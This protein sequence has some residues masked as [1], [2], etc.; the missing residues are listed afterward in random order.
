MNLFI[1]IGYSFWPFLKKL[2]VSA[3]ESYQGFS[4]IRKRSI[5]SFA[6]LF[7]A[8][9]F[10][11][12]LSQR[13]MIMPNSFFEQKK[14]VAKE[15]SPEFNFFHVKG[16]FNR[17]ELW[18]LSE[19]SV[20][21]VEHLIL[22]ST[23]KPLR[24]RLKK[25]LKEGLALSSKYQIDPFWALAIMWTESH[26]N[27]EAKSYA[28]ASGLMQLMPKTAAFLAG[29][30]NWEKRVPKGF[31][32]RSDHEANMELGIFY[33]NKLLRRFK[34]NATLATVAYNMGPGWVSKQIEKKGPV[35]VKNNYL[36]KVRRAYRVL[37][38]SYRMYLS[39]TRPSFANTYFSQ[40]NHSKELT[41][42]NYWND[43]KF[44]KEEP[45]NKLNGPKSEFL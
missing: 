17:L 21:Q 31:D 3:M 28:N 36:A 30:L 1:A 39:E 13:H 43:L 40:N 19:L 10:Y 42:K 12:Q 16:S 33:L 37:T 32:L 26:F 5:L 15:K 27:H 6:V 34:G 4:L 11:L 35:G 20:E 9:S 7:L 29:H 24:G 18:R 8:P 41:F 22:E 2:I 23:P 38:S 25:Y 44:E 45:T 14:I